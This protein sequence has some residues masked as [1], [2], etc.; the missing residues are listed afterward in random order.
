MLNSIHADL[1]ERGDISESE[2][3]D[4]PKQ[5]K[6]FQLWTKYKRTMAIAASIAGVTALFISLLM[7]QFSPAATN[8]NVIQNDIK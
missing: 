1:V 7:T 3:A 5:G 6:V 2:E 4:E 8:K